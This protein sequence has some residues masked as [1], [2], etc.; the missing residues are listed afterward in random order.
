MYTRV[1][2]YF[3]HFITVPS[4]KK[5]TGKSSRAGAREKNTRSHSKENGSETL[6]IKILQIVKLAQGLIINSMFII[7]VLYFAPNYLHVGRSE[8]KVGHAVQDGRQCGGH[9]VT[10]VEA[11]A[12]TAAIL[13][14]QLAEPLHHSFFVCQPI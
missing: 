14:Q 12:Y 9:E 3:S 10:A 1:K 5:T 8:G 6:H 11:V 2:G 7:A 4:N 13:Q